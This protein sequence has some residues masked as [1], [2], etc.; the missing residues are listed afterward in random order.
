MKFDLDAL[1]VLQF[2]VCILRLNGARKANK[3]S[4]IAGVVDR[5]N[6]HLK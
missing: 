5:S 6:H 3:L 2:T 1:S 4:D